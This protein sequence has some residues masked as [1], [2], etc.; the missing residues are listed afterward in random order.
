MAFA[1]DGPLARLLCNTQDLVE[2]GAE[3]TGAVWKL[4][5][6]GRQLDAN[7]IRLTPGR[8]VDAHAEP[9]LDVLLLVMAGDGTLTSPDRDQAMTVGALFW[10]PRGSR[11]AL[12]AGPDGLSYLTIHR[13][14]PGLSIRARPD[15][16]PAPQQQDANSSGTN[17]RLR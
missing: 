11:R 6:R 14:R 2:S 5:E 9:D 8:H 15:G 7:L 3:A 16:A 10:L 17:P 4:A 13:R 1:S 12:A